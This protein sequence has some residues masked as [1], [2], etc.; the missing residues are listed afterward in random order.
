MPKG[1]FSRVMSGMSFSLLQIKASNQY[2]LG[3]NP[4]EYIVIDSMFFKTIE[5]ETVL[6]D[7]SVPVS[8]YGVNYVGSIT[9]QNGIWN[10]IEFKCLHDPRS[11][12]VYTAGRTLPLYAA[13][14]Y[15]G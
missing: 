15:K 3:L 10:C 6:R 13:P 5:F 12:I 2:K 8:Q 14:Q 11:L 1:F 9:S 4:I 7:I